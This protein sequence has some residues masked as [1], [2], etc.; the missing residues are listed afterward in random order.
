MLTPARLKPASLIKDIYAMAYMPIAL[1]G[2]MA[3]PALMIGQSRDEHSGLLSQITTHKNQE[4]C[5]QGRAM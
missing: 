5:Y 2:H 3:I 1:Q 4:Y